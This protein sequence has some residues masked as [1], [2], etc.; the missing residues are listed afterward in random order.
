MKRNI[1]P[2]QAQQILGENDI[3]VSLEEAERI[4]KIMYDFGEIAVK[5][6]KKE[7]EVAAKKIK[8]KPK[9]T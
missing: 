7:K 5:Q 8:R 4:I 1:T 9:N 2:E 3:V 6:I